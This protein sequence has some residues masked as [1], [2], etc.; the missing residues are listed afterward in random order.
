MRTEKI[1]GKL[2]EISNRDFVKSVRYGLVAVDATG[3]ARHFCGYRFKPTL[4]DIENLEKELRTDKSFGLT[5]EHFTL[6]EAP[7]EVVE[8][9]LRELGEVEDG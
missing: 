6:E 7:K 1:F 3:A 2:W 9:Y 4:A 5:G 8:C